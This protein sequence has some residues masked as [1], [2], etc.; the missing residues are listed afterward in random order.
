[1]RKLVCDQFEVAEI[2]ARSGAKRA[3]EAA[4]R[5]AVSTAYY[6]LFQALCEM[7]ARSLVGRGQPWDVCT[8]IFR[9]LDHG[10]TRTQFSE[11]AADKKH[12][13]GI[14]VHEIGVAFT[15][16]QG[17]R[18]WADYN[19]EPHPEADE[20]T[21]QK[22]A[23]EEALALIETA[24]RAVSKLD[25]LDRTIQLKL[26]IRLVARTRKDARR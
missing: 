15:E 14:T 5:R 19:P 12:P 18:E 11:R 1:M 4:L 2:L 22:F 7:S 21:G 10:W 16:L 23:R 3:S 24:R 13:L 25:G 17:A 6:G 8:P 26:A 20:A 9:S